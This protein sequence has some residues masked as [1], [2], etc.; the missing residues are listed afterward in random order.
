MTFAPAAAKP[1][2]TAAPMPPV[3]PVR[4]TPRPSSP[5]PTLHVIVSLLRSVRALS[6]LA[7]TFSLR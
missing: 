5:A 1:L 6:A 2:A 4:M 7:S 3:A